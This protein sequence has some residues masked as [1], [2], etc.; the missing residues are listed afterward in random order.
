MLRGRLHRVDA[1]SRKGMSHDF[2]RD[3]VAASSFA[4][5]ALQALP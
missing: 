5:R 4:G 1:S 2:D 3:A